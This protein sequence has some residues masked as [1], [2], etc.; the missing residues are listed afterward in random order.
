VTR[1]ERPMARPQEAINRTDI[2]G[3]SKMGQTAHAR[4]PQSAEARVR[5]ALWWCGSTRRT[6]IMDVVRGRSR[7]TQ[8]T[9]R[10]ERRRERERDREGGRD[11]ERASALHLPYR[12]WTHAVA[13][14]TC[15][16]RINLD[17]VMT[18]NHSRH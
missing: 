3:E 12:G 15:V 2:Q 6:E 18:A 4:P 10:V 11:R 14:G 1:P 16:T 9:E 17:A 13:P 5:D 7:R 8:D